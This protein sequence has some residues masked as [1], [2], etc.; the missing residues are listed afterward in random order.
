MEAED[1]SA[2]WCPRAPVFESGAEARAY[3]RGLKRRAVRSGAEFGLLTSWDSIVT[4]LLPRRQRCLAGVPRAERDGA[5]EFLLNKRDA[6]LLGLAEPTAGQLPVFSQYACAATHADLPL[7]CLSDYKRSLAGLW[8]GEGAHPQAQLEAAPPWEARWPGAV[9]RGGATGGGVTAATNP[10]LRLCALSAAWRS[11]R[12]HRRWLLDAALTSWNPRHKRS[13][14]GVVRVIDPATAAPPLT[15]EDVGPHNFLTMR[16]QAQWRY[17]VLLDGN[18]GASR[19][20]ELAQFRFTVMMCASALP[21]VE[22]H[23][24]LV[25]WVHFVPLRADLA[26]VEER[27]WWCRAND[28]EAARIALALAAR[29]VPCTT[30]WA[31]EERLCRRISALPAASEATPEAALLHVWQRCRA[32]VYCLVVGNRLALFAPFANAEFRNDWSGDMVTSPRNL[33]EFLVTAAARFWPEDVLQD[34]SRWWDNG[35]LICN[36]MP[37]EIWG[38][39]MLPELARLVHRAAAALDGGPDARRSRMLRGSDGEEEEQLS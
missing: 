5:R 22:L 12:R 37:R 27:I 11:Q 6:P 35:S 8:V 29:L 1:A 33:R 26:D 3:R 23:S 28:A 14:D 38:C 18:V 4:L 20:G 10:R 31:M 15:R 32:A 34:P 39:A 17:Y 24:G 30:S 21:Q 16:Q 25:P 2:D 7:P 19:L 36:V 13:A 9:F